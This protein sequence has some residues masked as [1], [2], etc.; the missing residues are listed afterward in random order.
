MICEMIK[1]EWV[2]FVPV[3]LPICLTVWDEKEIS[4][5]Y[6]ISRGTISLWLRKPFSDI[7]TFYIARIEGDS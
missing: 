2:V 1:C 3:P 6:R 5:Q 4:A 7:P